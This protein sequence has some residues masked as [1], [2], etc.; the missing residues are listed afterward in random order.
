MDEVNRAYSWPPNMAGFPMH[1]SRLI[2]EDLS[3][4]MCF[5]YSGRLLQKSVEGNFVAKVVNPSADYFPGVP[6][7]TP[8]IGGPDNAHGWAD[9]LSRRNDHESNGFFNPC[10]GF[11][12]RLGS[13]VTSV[14]RIKIYKTKAQI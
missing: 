6:D 5:V 8:A 12:L 2:Q 10:S 13:M 3:V 11:F 7:I 14:A 1:L 9:F 4:V